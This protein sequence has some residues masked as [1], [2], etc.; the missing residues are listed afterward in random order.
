MGELTRRE[1]LKRSA[2]AGGVVWAAPMLSSGK[3]W[4]QTAGCCTCNGEIIYAKFAPGN[5][6]TCQNQCLQ[7]GSMTRLDFRDCLLKY[8]LVSLCDDVSTNDDTASI[9][10]SSDV[11]PIKFAIKSQNSCF[12]ARCNEGF[13]TL[14]TWSTSFNAEDYSASNIFP[15]PSASDDDAMVQVY[16]GGPGGA[17]DVR[18]TGNLPG[19]QRP[20]GTRCG[21]TRGLACSCAT[22][23]TGVFFTTVGIND[24]LNFIEMELCVKNLSKLDCVPIDCH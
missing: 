16:T 22:P 10:F 15:D 24:K 18:C 23:I 2:V 4:G 14:Y 8:G 9:A 21:H 17:G 13:S 12:I 7:P 6:Q 19:S 3:A 5:A 11:T 1:L 20:L